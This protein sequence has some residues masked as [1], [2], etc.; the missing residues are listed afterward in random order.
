M[1]WKL[2]LAAALLCFSACFN[3]EPPSAAA[4]EDEGRTDNACVEV[5]SPCEA[6]VDCCDFDDALPVGSSACVDPGDE[7]RCASICLSAD[8]CSSGCCVALEGVNYGACLDVDAC[9]N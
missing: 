1:P 5:E 7:P 2:S 3:P 9:E 6:N 8:D 4:E